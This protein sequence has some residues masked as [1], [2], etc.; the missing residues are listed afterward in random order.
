MLKT[1][2]SLI[3]L[4]YFYSFPIIQLPRFLPMFCYQVNS[5]LYFTEQK[6]SK[7]WAIKVGSK[8]SFISSSLFQQAC[9]KSS[10]FRYSC[11]SCIS[12]LLSQFVCLTSNRESQSLFTSALSEHHPLIPLRSLLNDTAEVKEGKAH[13]VQLHKE[14][15]L[16]FYCFLGIKGI[17]AS[18]GA[19]G[20]CSLTGMLAEAVS[21]QIFPLLLVVAKGRSKSNS[22]CMY[23]CLQSKSCSSV[24]SPMWVWRQKSLFSVHHKKAQRAVMDTK[25]AISLLILVFMGNFPGKKIEFI[26]LYISIL[27]QY[28]WTKQYFQGMWD[29]QTHTVFKVAGQDKDV[30]KLSEL[31]LFLVSY[32]SS[33]SAD[34]LTLKTCPLNILRKMRLEPRLEKL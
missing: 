3:C 26:F 2:S 21:S 30:H 4:F 23:L 28:G 12:L 10:A 25:I 19:S 29:F 33:T 31:S 24:S 18:P 32:Y 16:V 11:I 22:I 13:N 15:I 5:A 34:S 6:Q 27:L 8:W 7:Y 1:H 20:C 17:R 14:S 9:L